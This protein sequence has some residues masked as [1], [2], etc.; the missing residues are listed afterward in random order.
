MPLSQLP[1][2]LSAWLTDI[3]AALDR[4]SAPRLLL[5]LVGALFAKGRRTVTSWF[6]A[7]G[8]TGEFRPAYNA[9][10]AA[11]RRA[12]A[13]AYRLLCLALKPLMRRVS[14]DHVLFAIDDTPTARYGLVLSRRFLQS[15][16]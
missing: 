1:D 5:L 12:D 13:L 2:L 7:A 15:G 4:R 8:I 10:W 14:G 3:S 6:R 9:L 16:G 11:G